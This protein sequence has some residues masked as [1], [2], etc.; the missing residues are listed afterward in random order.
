MLRRLPVLWA[1]VSLAC[2]DPTPTRDPLPDDPPDDPPDEPLPERPVSGQCPGCEVTLA[3]LLS[4]MTDLARLAELEP[5]PYTHRQQSSY[6]RR[7]VSPEDPEGWFANDDHTNFLREEVR[8]G[9]TEYIMADIEGP[10]VI[11]RLWSATP[12]G[13]LRIYLDDMDTPAIEADMTALMDG[14]VEPFGEPF[15]YVAALGYNLYFPLGF[16][17]RAVVSTDHPFQPDVHEPFFYHVGYRLYPEDVVVEPYA[18]AAVQAQRDTIAAAAERLLEPGAEVAELDPSTERPLSLTP[19]GAPATFEIEGGGRVDAF[20]VTPSSQQVAALRRTVVVVVVDGEETVRVPVAELFGTG[21]G[22]H[23]YASFPVTIGE[24]GRL[25]FRFP[26]PFERTLSMRL[27]AI[28]GDGVSLSG[29][30]FV[31]AAPFTDRTLLLYGQWRFSGV[32]PTRPFWDWNHIHIR[33]RGH[34]VGSTMNITNPA[35]E[36]W[37]EGDEKVYVDGETFPSFFGTG[38][39]DYY[40]YAWLSPAFFERPYHHQANVPEGPVNAGTTSNGRWHVLDP[41]PFRRELIFDMEVW[42][43]IDTSLELDAAMLFYARPGAVHNIPG[44]EPE[45]HLVPEFVPP[46]AP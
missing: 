37:G 36:W 7:A 1:L 25:S 20:E 27:E 12:R 8:D 6:D 16:A 34:F 29:R 2:A 44:T 46:P 13:T 10:G 43:W 35:A 39:E 5:I 22:L 26:M 23:P 28:G 15:A 17:E 42:H 3:S 4:D 45:D 14:R 21:P 24:D 31:R 33:G 32:V 41:I 9:R 19:G 38:T 11:Q 18:P 30:A 40:G